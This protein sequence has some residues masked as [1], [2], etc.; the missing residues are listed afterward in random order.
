MFLPSNSIDD[1]GEKY[2]SRQEHLF[3][4]KKLVKV[5]PLAMVD[6]LLAVQHCNIESL[7]VNTFI[8][9]QIEMKKLKFHTPDINGKSKCNKMHVGK[10][11]LL[12]P[13]LQVHG[14][15]MGQVTE[16]GYLGDTVSNDGP[17]SKM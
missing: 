13:D 10:E 4:Y 16:N 8:N 15:R 3:T 14:T 1:L 9:T 5:T 12:C 7:A 2:I 17:N 6:D 11:N